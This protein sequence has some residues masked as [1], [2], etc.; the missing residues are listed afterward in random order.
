MSYN[1]DDDIRE[2][3]RRAFEEAGGNRPDRGQQPPRRPSPPRPPVRPPW[4]DR[5]FWF[6]IIPFI[7]L[8]SFNW[9]VTTFTDWLWFDAVD[10]ESVW[11]TQWGFQLGS[12]AVAFVIAALVLLLNTRF[13]LNGAQKSTDAEIFNPSDFPGFRAFVNGVALVLA[14]LFALTA[15][16]R[17]ETLI[18]FAYREP[19]AVNDPLFGRNLSFYF[20]ELPFYQFVQGWLTPLLVFS[21]IAVAGIYALHNLEDLR[22]GRWQPQ[23]LTP[24]RRHIAVLGA[25]VFLLLAVDQLLNRFSLVYSVRNSNFLAGAGYTDATVSAPIYMIAAVL[26]VIVAAALLL[27]IPSFNWRPLAAAA[28]VWLI[29]TTVVRTIAPGIVQSYVVNPNE[30]GREAPY[31]ADSID[32]TRRAYGLDQIETRDLGEVELLDATDLSDNEAALSNIRLWDYRVLPDN[33]E[34]LQALRNFYDFADIDI[35]R[36]I[37]DGEMRQVML[38]GRELDKGLLPNNTWVNQKL[39]YTHG[40]GVVMNPVDR[41]TRDGQPEFFISNLPP[42]SPVGIELDRPEIYYGELMDDY[43][44]AASAREEINYP[45][46]STNVRSRYE[47]TGGVLMSNPLRRLALSFRFG[48]V[49]VLL[50]DDITSSTR[51]MYYRPVLERARTIT[52]FLSFDPDP[53]LVVVDGRLMWVADAYTTSNAYPYSERFNISQGQRTVPVNYIRNV[54]KV[55]V[56][57]YNGTIN[58]YQIDTEDPIVNV[59]ARAFPELFKP[60]DEFPEELQPHLRYPELLFVV[61]SRIYQRYHMESTEVFYGQSDVWDIPQEVFSSSAGVASSRLQ[62]MEP[63]YVIFRLPGEQE[64]EYLLIQPYNLEDRPNM[65]AWMAARNDPANYGELIV[66]EWSA[67]DVAGPDQV[68]TRIDQ[69]T[70]ISQQLTLWNQQGSAVTRGNLIVIPLNNSFL[71]VEP[72]FLSSENNALPELKRVIVSNG[73][74]VIMRDTLAEALADLLDESVSTIAATVLDGEAIDLPEE[75]E[76]TDTPVVTDGSV[77]SLIEAANASFEA[78]QAAQQAGDWAAYGDALEALEAQLQ[79]LM[80]LSSP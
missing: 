43:V 24:L 31:I 29:V 46:G 23:S 18:R 42:E 17:W 7:L 30:L 26:A 74:D 39:E 80:E 1:N 59:Y 6:L 21:I 38:S 57:A 77:E 4:R 15:S 68:E 72:L 55:T 70:E 49:N 32:Y 56:D 14:F 62:E 37:I 35:D 71:Y 22:Q 10:Y 3:F 33:Y 63:Y 65:V 76:E 40:Y 53:Y 44:F 61:Q 13:A 34:R 41:F 20:F 64:T 50:S 48:D 51:A 60:F 5:R 9:I 8:L 19:A 66:Y 73:F 36:Y 52:P 67:Q 27:Q 2:I 58:Y 78:A 25:L 12:F 79:Q 75:S 45:T 54:A 69:D 28:I 47:G 16:A 11:V